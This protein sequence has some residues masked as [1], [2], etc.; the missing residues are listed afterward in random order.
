MEGLLA[1]VDQ[2]VPRAS[3]RALI[4]LLLRYP[5]AF[6]QWES[7]LGR[8][9]ADRHQIETGDNCPF[10]QVLRQ[11][12]TALLEAIEFQVYS[13]LQ[14]DLIQ[15]AQSEWVSNVVMP[16]TYDGSSRGMPILAH[17]EKIVFFK[18]K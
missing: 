16:M 2:A 14:A 15:P 9:T 1:R 10:R 12:P 5:A 11:H 17:N 7:D 8:T 3:R 18:N 13:M 6:S 4:E